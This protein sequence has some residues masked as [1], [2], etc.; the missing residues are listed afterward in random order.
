M[1]IT[2]TSN[3]DEVEL[4][5]MADENGKKPVSGMS[6]S[7]EPPARDLEQEDAMLVYTS[8]TTGRPKV[9]HK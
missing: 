3:P 4:A 6:S 8:G 7:F 1:M 5:V 2:T 9:L